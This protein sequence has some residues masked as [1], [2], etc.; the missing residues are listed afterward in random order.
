MEI[1]DNICNPQFINCDNALISYFKK[2]KC[3]LSI[4]S[5]TGVKFFISRQ[6][7]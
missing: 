5:V 3:R 2:D 6:V 1:K 4:F 7:I